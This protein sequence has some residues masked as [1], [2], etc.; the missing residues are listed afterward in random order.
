MPR[1][2]ERKIISLI[3]KDCGKQ[4]QERPDFHGSGDDCA[5]LTVGQ[6]GQ[7]SNIAVTTDTMVEGVHFSMDYFSAWHVGRKLAAVNLSDIAA[8]GASPKWAFLNLGLP[9]KWRRQPQDFLQPFTRGLCSKLGAFGAV[10]AGG[11]TVSCPDRIVLTLTLIGKL[12]ESRWLSRSGASPGDIICCSGYL[13]ESAAGLLILSSG[14]KL[15]RRHLRLNRIVRRRLE[16]RH[17][18]PIPRVELGR[19]LISG[20]FAS[21]AMDMSDGLATDL[22]HL[23]NMSKTGALIYEDRIPVSR[24]VKTLCRSLKRPLRPLD[25][26][27][28]GGEDYELLWTVPPHK[29][30]ELEREITRIKGVWP[31]VLGTVTEKTGVWLSGKNGSREI[32]YQGYEH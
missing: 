28:G 13:G 21:A 27:T 1:I 18:D 4:A 32:S 8:Q 30:R 25:L 3:L 11:D 31:F 24:A 2:P 19:L 20:G 14:S 7:S 29:Q 6:E 5:V 15:N 23:C 10:L 22:A 26:A 12:P 17:L 9:D 16:N